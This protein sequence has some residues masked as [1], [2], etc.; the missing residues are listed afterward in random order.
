MCI[1]INFLIFPNSQTFSVFKYGKSYRLVGLK[2]ELLF[3]FFKIGCILG[4]A[5]SKANYNSRLYGD[6]EQFRK[7]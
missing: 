7:T 1:P 4:P 5:R 2:E 3:M 6:T